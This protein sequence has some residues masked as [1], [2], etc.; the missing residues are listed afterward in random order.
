MSKESQGW[1]GSPNRELAGRNQ[2]EQSGAHTEGA[3]HTQLHPLVN[4]KSEGSGGN[5]NGN[6]QFSTEKRKRGPARTLSDEERAKR[7]LE[8]RRYYQKNREKIAEYRR[9]WYQGNQEKKE[10]K[11]EYLKRYRQINKEKLKEANKRYRHENKEKIQELERRYK[12]QNKE[13]IQERMIRW[14]HENKEKIQELNRIRLE[15][16]IQQELELTNRRWQEALE[17]LQIFPFPKKGK[18]CPS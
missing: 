15:R 18:D 16:E 6:E 14:R 10:I 11:K 9:R 8:R 12:Q 13:K 4:T 1:Q 7:Q 2:K 3:A 17:A 5:E